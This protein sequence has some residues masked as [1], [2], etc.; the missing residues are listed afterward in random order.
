MIAV[1]GLGCLGNNHGIC[2]STFVQWSETEVNETRIKLSNCD[3]DYTVYRSLEVKHR[4]SEA[5]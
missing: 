2:R 5:D 4:L 1:H 3:I